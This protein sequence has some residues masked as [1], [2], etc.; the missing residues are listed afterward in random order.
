MSWMSSMSWKFVLGLV[1]LT[2]GASAVFLGIGVVADDNKT[3]WVPFAIGT[4][5]VGVAHRVLVKA[6]APREA[7]RDATP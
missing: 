5:L 2:L 3:G 6:Q 4:A 1:F 7:E